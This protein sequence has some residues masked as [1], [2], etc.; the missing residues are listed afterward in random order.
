MN[1]K[2]LTF[3][4]LAAILAVAFFVISNE[5]TNFNKKPH[6]AKGSKA[7][8]WDPDDKDCNTACAA[9]GN[10]CGVIYNVCCEKTAEC[11]EHSINIPFVGKKTWKTCGK[12]VDDFKC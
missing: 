9:V 10:V 2:L 6:H 8:R 7:G 1:K 5:S 11:K 4:S 12:S 3:I